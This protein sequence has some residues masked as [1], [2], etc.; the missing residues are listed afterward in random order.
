M[1][2]E[3]KPGDSPGEED[4]W[5]KLAENLFGI[6]FTKSSEPPPEL[7]APAEE[8]PAAEDEDASEEVVEAASI[9]ADEPDVPVDSGDPFGVFDEIE[10]IDNVEEEDDVAAETVAEDASADNSGE[11]VDTFWDPLNSW[12]W[13]DEPRDAKPKPESRS[14]RRS[15]P[16]DSTN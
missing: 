2:I 3:F 15:A 12:D 14:P 11:E 10:D 5:A 4:S 6:N 16:A 1:T 8:K 13:G 7:P 9:E